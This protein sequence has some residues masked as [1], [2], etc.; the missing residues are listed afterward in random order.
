VSCDHEPLIDA[1]AA[2][3]WVSYADQHLPVPRACQA[4]EAQFGE[5][6]AACAHCQSLLLPYRQR[7]VWAWCSGCDHWVRTAEL[8]AVAA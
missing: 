8:R 2:G 4:C 6:A 3:R 5:G 1:I 7:C